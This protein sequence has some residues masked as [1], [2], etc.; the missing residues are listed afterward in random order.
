VGFSRLWLNRK[1]RTSKLTFQEQPYKDSH[2]AQEASEADA[3]ANEIGFCSGKEDSP[4]KGTK[5]NA[6]G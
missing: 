4:G 5:N 6:G 2:N 1:T 3:E